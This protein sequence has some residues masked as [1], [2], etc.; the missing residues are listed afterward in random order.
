MRLNLN[1]NQ[2]GFIVR[3][4]L[5]EEHS[6][7]LMEQ[8]ADCILSSGEPI[9]YFGGEGAASSG[10]SSGSWN[11]TG[12]NMKGFVA[13]YQKMKQVRPFYVDISLA[14]KYSVISTVLII[15]VGCG[16]AALFDK[17]W[18][19]LKRNPGAFYLVGK[20]CSTTSSR[21]FV[22]SSILNR[23]IP[24][25]DTPNNLYRQLRTQLQSNAVSY[26]GYLGFI[27]NDRTESFD[28]E[29]EETDQ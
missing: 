20:N 17:F 26:S 22:A 4:K 1:S 19:D 9:G 28:I 6:P 2:V 5:N 24:G 14:K 15:D 23:G 3:G 7:G 29:I 11:S 21:A 18:N 27:K 10:S 8:H 16:K 13:G 25:L 12:L